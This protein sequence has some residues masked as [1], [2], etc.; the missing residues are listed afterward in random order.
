MVVGFVPYFANGR[1]IILGNGAVFSVEDHVWDHDVAFVEPQ[2]QVEFD[3]EE[4][5]GFERE[6]VLL[7][8]INDVVFGNEV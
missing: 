5:V 6:N 1:V 3:E 7:N 2:G 4:E 8:F